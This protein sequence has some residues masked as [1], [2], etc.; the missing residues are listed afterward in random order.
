MQKQRYIFLL[1]VVIL[2]SAGGV[3]L[4]AQ[5]MESGHMVIR[6]TVDLVTLDVAV[7][8]KKGN[9]VTG[10]RPGNF[11]VYEDGLRE[12]LAT[13][14]E[15]NEAPRTVAGFASRAPDSRPA[16][17]ATGLASSA[18]AGHSVFILFD[19][20]NY[21]YRSFVFAQ[22]SIAEFVRSLDHI[23]RVAFYSYSRDFSRDARLTANR[24]LVLRGVRS[25]VAGDD[26]A[27][28]NSLLLTLED[29]AQFSG[30]KVVVVFSNGPDNSS[31][32]APEDVLEL[33]QS[34]GVPIYMVSTRKAQLDPLTVAVFDR[35]SAATGGKAY[36]ARNWEDEQKAFSS[37]RNDLLHL[38]SLSYYPQ[39]NP[40]RGWRKITVRL[41][42]VHLSHYHIR[43]RS[44]YRLTWP[45]APTDDLTRANRNPGFGVQG[46]A[47]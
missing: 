30:R 29:A 35:V 14:A 6:R 24:S 38:Y 45:G 2:F 42:G 13:F 18:G 33:A 15:A 4:P 26:A 9:Y 25:T 17:S 36:F 11:A 7:T 12:K 16:L 41:V 1:V 21:M 22:D 5:Q 46:S 10:L 37:I 43:T 23:D 31:V 34:E 39:V 8:D 28:Y 19:T 3:R 32:V 47:R 20:S 44:G 40:N 27:L